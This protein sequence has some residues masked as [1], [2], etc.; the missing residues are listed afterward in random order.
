[1]PWDS[2][3]ATIRLSR[4]FFHH[5]QSPICAMPRAH[6]HHPRITMGKYYNE[7]DIIK[8]EKNGKND[9]ANPD[10]Y[11][12]FHS[13]EY[14]KIFGNKKKEADGRD[15][16]GYVKVC[17]C[18]KYCCRRTR[19]CIHLRYYGK[20]IGANKIGLSY[21]NLCRLKRVDSKNEECHNVYVKKSCWFP[22]YWFHG[23][24]GVCWPFRIAVIG[25][26]ASILS[27][28]KEIICCITKCCC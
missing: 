12:F 23:D 25:L 11:A 21:G 27:F 9:V 17:A 19:R 7:Y 20:S 28:L 6:S 2:G 4:L 8:Y 1:M 10:N 26:G 5:H 14:L 13:C 15:I 18:D 24:S 16:Y 3:R 22:Y